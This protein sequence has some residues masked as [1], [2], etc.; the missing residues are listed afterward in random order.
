MKENKTNLILIAAVT[1]FIVFLLAGA[2]IFS[3]S[4]KKTSEIQPAAQDIESHH[5]SVPPDESVFN[6]LFG[7]KAPNFILESFEGKAIELEKLNGKKV[8]LFFTEGLMCYPACWN[9]M[10]AFGED[11]AFNNSDVITLN[12]AVDN[13]NDWKQAIEK[14]PELA[15]TI[16]LFDTDR[17]VSQQYGA[18]T[19]P[20]SMHKGQFPGHTYVIID[21]EGII[22]FT[23]DD[24]LM[25]VRNDELKKELEKIK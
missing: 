10:A 3:D 1:G 6:S 21:R 17:S 23:Y 2:V 11:S 13:N 8:V 18:L 15:K 25:G 24:P 12:I 20:S 5:Q 4:S 22:K 7:K 9:Q 14:M 16:V 19:L